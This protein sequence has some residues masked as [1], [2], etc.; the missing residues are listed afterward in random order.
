MKV[1]FIDS[2]HP[3]LQITL[4]KN[5]FIC[6]YDLSLSKSEIEKKNI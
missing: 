5:N 4:E 1:L 6:H 2:T 3:D